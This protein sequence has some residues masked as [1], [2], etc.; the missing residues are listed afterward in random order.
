M[1]TY[2][3]PAREIPVT[4]EVDVIVA[5]GGPSGIGAA[6]SSARLGLKTLLVEQA[7]DVGGVSTTGLMSHWTGKTQGGLYE[8][9]LD[10]S[11][12]Q[13]APRRQT[14]DPEKLKTVYL[15]LLTEAGVIIRTYTFASEP[16]IEDDTVKGLIVES[17]SGRE[18]FLSK[19]LIDCTGDGDI[20][21]KSKVPY[22]TG[23]EEDGK[24][25]PMTLMFKVAG[26]KAD[27]IKF[28]LP[29][30]F[31]ENPAV[32]LGGIQDLGKA[33][34]KSPIGHV[35]L[36]RTARPD[37]ITVNMTNSLD[38]DGTKAEDLTKAH[39]QC[40]QQIEPIVAFLREFVP[41]FENCYAISSASIVGVRETRHF[42]GEKRLEVEDILQARVFDDWAVTWAHFNLD[43]HNITGAGLDKTGCQAKFTQKRS[44]TI[45]YGCLVPKNVDGLLLAG[46]CISGSHL[47]HSSFRVMPICV[48]IGQAAGTAAYVAVKNG[49]RVRDI[50]VSE[51]QKV[52]LQNGVREPE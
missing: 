10:K 48:N 17:K 37:V 43:V 24:M 36:Y 38:V 45:P 22:R 2:I 51:L 27:E 23:R 26:V 18:A 28:H 32:P 14:I 39:I 5:G 13:G 46:R 52:L 6:L 21:A 33:H 29:E 42:E 34:L 12:P 1:K 44:Y 40:R 31:E 11:M 4:N 9:I 41:G 16:I 3:E 20:A 8:E 50:D 25:Q 15:S 35:L 47:A 7:G 30:A 19:V 49:Q